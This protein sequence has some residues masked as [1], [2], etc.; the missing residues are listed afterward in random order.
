MSIFEQM[1]GV[2]KEKKNVM[3]EV[4]TQRLNRVNA[5]TPL[6]ILADVLNAFKEDLETERLS[7]LYPNQKDYDRIMRILNP[8]HRN[9]H[10]WNMLL[11]EWL[12]YAIRK[13]VIK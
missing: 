12:D 9:Y 10:Y 4:A 11:K 6:T 13:G 5:R 3:H 7:K 8:N 1:A 2:K